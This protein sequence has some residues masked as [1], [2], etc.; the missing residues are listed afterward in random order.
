[1]LKMTAAQ[2]K[3]VGW[4]VF[5]LLVAMLYSSMNT[6]FLPLHD[7]HTYVYAG[8]VIAW[9]FL[10]HQRII[11]RQ[12]RGHLVAASAFM[13]ILFLS[14]LVRW[15]CLKYNAIALDY[16]WYAYY[17]SFVAVPLCAFLAALC[18]GKEERDRPLRWAKWLWIVQLGF[19][20]I[21]F[22]NSWHRLFFDFQDASHTTYTFGVAYYA[23]AGW[24]AF[25][26]IATLVIIVKRCQIDTVRKFWFVPMGGML[27]FMGLIVWYY[28]ND[29]SPSLFGVKLYNLQ[30]VFCL[31]VI[32]PFETMIQLGILPNNSRYDLFFE[33]IPI[34]ASILDAE[35]KVVYASKGGVT[36]EDG[37]RRSEKKIHGGKIIFY[38]DIT[39]IRRL[40]EEIQKVTEALEEEND[41]IRQENEIRSE[42]ISY[43]T[44][45]HLYD[46]IAGAVREKALA[47][48]A[49][50]SDLNGVEDEEGKAKLIRAM[51]LGAYVKRMGNMMLITEEAKRVSTKE[52][53]S[54][55]RES[56][57][58]F[59][60]T[61]MLN[62]FQEKGERLL[63]EKVILLSYELLEELLENEEEIYSLMILLDA[64]EGYTVRIMLDTERIQVE[65]SW[66]RAELE[67]AG[68]ELQVEY[69]DETW[70]V[71]LQATAGMEA[72]DEQGV[73]KEGVL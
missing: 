15:R 69:V 47:I 42:R 20:V 28:V 53:G 29:G 5:S 25:L 34:P 17:V 23:C 14:R 19:A 57:E 24:G 60:M 30:E 21:V 39:V 36:Q 9:G 1:M 13:L 33:N 50:L 4:I 18:V 67:A 6:S 2:K 44:K 54:A 7:V 49:I 38:E 11:H 12:V 63:P 16:A 37:M 65:A 62:D 56:L 40:D 31:A 27:F 52:L 73:G 43:E 72:H 8:L 61:G 46:K 64:R 45:N 70:R 48:V 32:F 71:T 68:L 41:L 10:V 59:G 3:L 58:Y 55:V 22:T 35:G 66:R 51:I 26:G